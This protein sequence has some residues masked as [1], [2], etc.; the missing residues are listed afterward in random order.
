V[1]RVLYGHAD[2]SRIVLPWVLPPGTPPGYPPGYSPWVLP[3]GTPPGYS[4]WV[5][6]GY[7]P[8]T[9]GADLDARA[10]R[11]EPPQRRGVA[12]RG[13]DLDRRHPAVG[14]VE[15]RGGGAEQ[16]RAE[17]SRAGGG[18]PLVGVLA[19]TRACARRSDCPTSP[20]NDR[21]STMGVPCECHM[22]TT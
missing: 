21:V 10:V 17:L 13:G 8:G 6:P 3:L 1:L 5:L 15:L 14:V 20:L 7:S 19:R 16:S 9:V 11:R 2:G 22:S 18:M 12:V 4:P